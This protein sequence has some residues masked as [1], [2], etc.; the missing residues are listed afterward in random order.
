[1][2]FQKNY[3]YLISCMIYSSQLQVLKLKYEIN[4]MYKKLKQT[5]IDPFNRAQLC[6]GDNACQCQPNI[7][8]KLQ[9]LS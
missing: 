8:P 2:S 5:Y 4:I 7:V 9:K 1:M 6:R 3:A